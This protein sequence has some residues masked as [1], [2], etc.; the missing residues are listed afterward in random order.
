MNKKAFEMQFFWIFIMI[1]GALILTFFLTLAM[2]QRA[3]GEQK[4]MLELSRDVEAVFTSALQTPGTV[5]NITIPKTGVGLKCSAACDCNFLIGETS[6]SFKDKIIFGPAELKD[7]DMLFWTYEWKVPYRV[8]GLLL[9]TNPNVRYIFVYDTAST[10][11]KNLKDKLAKELP[12]DMNKA[13][14][15]NIPN[16]PGLEEFPHT[17][18]VYL[19][20]NKGASFAIPAARKV[21]ADAVV[22]NDDK[23][24]F[25]KQNSANP[26]LFE[27]PTEAPLRQA[28]TLELFYDRMGAIYA[29]IYADDANMYRCGMTQAYKKLNAITQLVINR[30]QEISQGAAAGCGVQYET[31]LTQS[32]PTIKSWE[33]G[34]QKSGQTLAT[35]EAANNAIIRQS[36]PQVY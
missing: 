14:V 1:A 28:D 12:P 33:F 19:E 29:A 18:I 10:Q 21:A 31:I 2:Q 3:S 7:F 36:C 23:I 26:S 8:T 5:Q 4:I 32:L 6:R 30:T 11:S 25:Y 13:F 27:R 15:E 17:R 16:A 34:T 35:L 22:I 9:V 24:L 20:Q